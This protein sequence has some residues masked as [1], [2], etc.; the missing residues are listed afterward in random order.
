MYITN[1]HEKNGFSYLDHRKR[2]H[3]CY[4]QPALI[5]N[6]QELKLHSGVSQYAIYLNKSVVIQRERKNEKGCA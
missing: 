2:P 1:V 5:N 3:N 4:Y 6:K